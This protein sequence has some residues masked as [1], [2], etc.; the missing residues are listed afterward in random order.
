MAKHR[1]STRVWLDEQLQERNFRAIDEFVKLY[2]SSDDPKEKIR[3]L[4]IVM[5]RL[6]PKARP[7]DAEGNAE[8]IP[9][10]PITPLSDAQVIELVK[11]ARG[12]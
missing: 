10:A 9:P 6:Y 2:F 3:L 1:F 12:A 5:D 4:E 8:N 7:E 11:K